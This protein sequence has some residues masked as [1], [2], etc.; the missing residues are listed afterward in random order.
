M[1]L[2]YI[3]LYSV[4]QDQAAT[5][6]FKEFAT[7]EEM[8]RRVVLYFENYLSTV[9]QSLDENGTDNAQISELEYQSE[10]LFKFIDTSFAE[11]VCLHRQEGHPDLWIPYSTE[12]VKES[13]YFYLRAQYESEMS[14]I[15]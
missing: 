3:L 2:P 13:I 6:C 7:K 9:G 10:D 4:S 15:N 11:L 1:S 14:I 12:W 5:R 8:A